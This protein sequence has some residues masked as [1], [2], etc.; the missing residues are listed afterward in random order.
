LYIKNGSTMNATFLVRRKKGGL[1]KYQDWYY[2]A[3]GV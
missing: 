1:K 2:F 3:I